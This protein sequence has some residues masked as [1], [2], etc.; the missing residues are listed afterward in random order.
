TV[1]VCA[2]RRLPWAQAH[3]STRRSRLKPAGVG[4]PRGL[5]SRSAGG[6]EPPGG[7]SRSVLVFVV[8]SLEDRSGLPTAPHCCLSYESLLSGRPEEVHQ[9][10]DLTARSASLRA[11]GQGLGSRARAR[12]FW[13]VDA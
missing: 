13:G 9:C 10:S 6:F 7:G 3:V 4:S 11:G 8:T 1:D 12:L 2:S 5:G